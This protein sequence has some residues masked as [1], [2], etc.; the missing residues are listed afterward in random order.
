ML[1]SIDPYLPAGTGMRQILP[2]IGTVDAGNTALLAER[3]AGGRR[4]SLS[5]IHQPMGRWELRENLLEN[6]GRWFYFGHVSATLDQPGSASVHL[7]DDGTEWGL[8]TPVNN[9]H[10]PLSALDLLL[11]TAA[12]ELGPSDREP[13]EQNQMGHTLWPMPPRV[14]LIACESG[15]DYRSSETFGLVMAILSSG[16]EV[17]TTTRWTL[18]SDSAFSAIAGE[19]IACGPTTELALAVDDSHRADDPVAALARWQRTRL[20]QWRSDPGL[21]TSPI[22]WASVATHLC[23]PREVSINGERVVR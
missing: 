19:P 23:P 7:D 6:P 22:T 20:E 16:A 11:G 13:A 3:I 4:T 5:G 14:A 10:L 21:V 1:Y 8:A 15:V 12:P 9:A 18:P 17:L 2:A